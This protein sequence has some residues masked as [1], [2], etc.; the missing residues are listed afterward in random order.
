VQ[1]T[2]KPSRIITD[3]NITPLTD[4]MLVLLIIFMVTATFL[5]IEPSLDVR[6]PSAVTARSRPEPECTITVSIAR[7]GALKVNGKPADREHLVD[8]LLA[9]A[10]NLPP[11]QRLVMVRGDR[12]ANYGTIIAVM[13][14]ARL[15]GLRQVALATESPYTRNRERE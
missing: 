14:A 3:I 10:R 4:V 11:G 5:V 1:R 9:A 7:D 12:D 15:V 2:H 6:L 13:D 8:A